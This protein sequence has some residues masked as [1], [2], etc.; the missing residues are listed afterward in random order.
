[1]SR[2]GSFAA[3]ATCIATGLAH[4]P[5]PLSGSPGTSATPF[6]GSGNPA[7]VSASRR[8]LRRSSR[9]TE[10]RRVDAMRI[11]PTRH[12]T[13]R[14]H[15]YMGS[16]AQPLTTRPEKVALG[17]LARTALVAQGIEQWPPE[18]CAQVRILPRAPLAIRPDQ[19]KDLV[20]AH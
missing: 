10:R 2:G 6:G 8:E 11:G 13:A 7:A 14:S 18:P 9:I 1:M 5:W 17:T 4:S 19:R 12:R 15:E 16:C 20:S 3:L